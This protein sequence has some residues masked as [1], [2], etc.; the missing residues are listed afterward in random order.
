[1]NLNGDFNGDGKKDLLVR[2]HSDEISVFCFL[3]RE[4]GFSSRP[5]FRFKCP[6]PVD[7]WDI[8]DL[9]GDGLSDLVVRVQDRNLFRIFTSQKQ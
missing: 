4:Q 9:N 5:D 6:E 8:K 1:L 3:S 2:D 7:W